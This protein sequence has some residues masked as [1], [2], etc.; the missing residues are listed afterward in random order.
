MMFVVELEGW[1]KR[2]KNNYTTVFIASCEFN[3]ANYIQISTG[4]LVVQFAKNCC[5]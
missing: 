4:S 2:T 1:R 5:M 3:V